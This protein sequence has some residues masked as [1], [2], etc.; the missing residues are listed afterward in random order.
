MKDVG[1]EPDPAVPNDRRRFP[2]HGD[3]AEPVYIPPGT[4]RVQFEEIP[5]KHAPFQT[6]VEPQP[7][8]VIRR[9]LALGYPMHACSGLKTQSNWKGLSPN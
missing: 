3:A 7:E 8:L 4:E 2:V 1:I 9:G 5:E 6:V